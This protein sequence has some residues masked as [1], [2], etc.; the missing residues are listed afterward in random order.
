MGCGVKKNQLGFNHHPHPDRSNIE[1]NYVREAQV[2]F[3]LPQLCNIQGRLQTAI[4]FQP[5]QLYC[6][7]KIIAGPPSKHFNGLRPQVLKPPP[8]NSTLH[9]GWCIIFGS[10]SWAGAELT[11]INKQ[12][13]NTV[14]SVCLYSL[15]AFYLLLL[16]LLGG[17][18]SCSAS[19]SAYSYTFLH[20]VVR[21]SVVCH[22]PAPA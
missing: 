3:A 8:L 4:F 2:S 5:N 14:L 11:S 13:L 9:P 7:I 20:S 16:L 15:S 10:Q 12:K 22:T 6:A 18:T 17:N 21:L 1:S 19:D